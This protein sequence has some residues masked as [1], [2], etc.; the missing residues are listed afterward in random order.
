TEGVHLGGRNVDQQHKTMKTRI[1][2]ALA[3]LTP[4]LLFADCPPT[5]LIALW[6]GQSNILDSIGNYDAAAKGSGVTYVAAEVG[7]G[8][9]FNG[10]S[11]ATIRVGSFTNFG[12]GDFTIEFWIKST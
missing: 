12:T 6:Q 3:L 1:L 7:A 8:F 4:L 11:D 9:A 10:T 5:G 2:C